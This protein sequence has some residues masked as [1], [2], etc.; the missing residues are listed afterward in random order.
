MCAVLTY[1]YKI[2]VGQGGGAARVSVAEARTRFGGSPGGLPHRSGA[3][4]AEGGHGGEVY[5]RSPGK[6]DL[7]LDLDLLCLAGG[8]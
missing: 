1:C 2:V 3:L 6:V 5:L 7:D 8:R 4:A